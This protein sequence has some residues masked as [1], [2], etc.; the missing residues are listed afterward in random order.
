MSTAKEITELAQHG[1]ADAKQKILANN[2]ELN[3]LQAAIT[4]SNKKMNDKIRK[5]HI[6]VSMIKEHE[7]DE[8]SLKDI[9]E[10]LK[11]LGLSTVPKSD[12]VPKDNIAQ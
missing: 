11:K 3:D 9:L 8:E 6:Y 4:E 12:D 5:L 7:D 10:L 1:I 2:K